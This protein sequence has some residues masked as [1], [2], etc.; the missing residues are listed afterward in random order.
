[1]M[2]SQKE[3]IENAKTKLEKLEIQSLKID[4]E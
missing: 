3:H 2:I 4:S 1:M